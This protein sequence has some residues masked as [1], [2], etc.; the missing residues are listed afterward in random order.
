MSEA[1]EWAGAAP[2]HNFQT[3]D[4]QREVRLFKLLQD[5]EMDQATELY[6]RNDPIRHASGGVDPGGGLR[7]IEPLIVKSTDIDRL[8]LEVLQ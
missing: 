6:W 1:K 8:D 2:W 7:M 3:P 5:G 4:D